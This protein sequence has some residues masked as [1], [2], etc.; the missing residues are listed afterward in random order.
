M[1]A[2]RSEKL[3]QPNAQHHYDVTEDDLPLSCPMPGMYLWNSH[4][5]VY[6]PSRSPAGRSAPTAARSTRSP[7]ASL[8]AAQA[9]RW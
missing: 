6:L 1:T 2:E 8:N 7:A 4:P 9:L 5:R 3:I